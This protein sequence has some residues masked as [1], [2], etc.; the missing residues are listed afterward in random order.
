[1]SQIGAEPDASIASLRVSG[2]ISVCPVCGS[3]PCEW[4][5]FGQDLIDNIMLTY[6]HENHG[7]KGGL[8][9]P[10]TGQAVPNSKVRKVMYKLFTYAKYDHLGKGDWIPILV[11][12]FEEIHELYPDPE[13]NYMGF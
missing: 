8:L 7:A 9:D 4:D 10:M 3:M 5:E 11:C 12:V 1:M 13:G 2:E 6:D